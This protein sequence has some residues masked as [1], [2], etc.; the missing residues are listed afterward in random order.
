MKDEKT[1]FNLT[2]DHKAFW[3]PGDY[4]TNEYSYSTTKLSEIDA[5]TASKRQ[6]EISVRTPAG[7]NVVQTPLMMKS[8]DGL[9]IN[10]HEAALVDYPAMYLAVDRQNFGVS[11]RLAPNAVWFKGF[12][13]LAMTPWRTIIVSD[14]AQTFSR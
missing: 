10:I 5:L 9:Y 2:G 3:I 8:A 12:S 4:D 6:V 14:K 7:D 11:A 13:K 1:E